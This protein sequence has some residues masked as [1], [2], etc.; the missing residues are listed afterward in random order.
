MAGESD[1]SLDQETKVRQLLVS[2]V[3]ANHPPG[4]VNLTLQINQSVT[5]TQ[6]FWRDLPLR[7]KSCDGIAIYQSFSTL[8]HSLLFF[9]PRSPS[10][11][12]RADGL[13]PTFEDE[14]RIF[15]TEGE[16]QIEGGE[17]RFR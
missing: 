12:F 8:P 15:P 14:S 7:S 3:A 9:E 10:Q 5:R 4:Q 11:G 1:P 16:G 13:I 2:I 6:G 17:A